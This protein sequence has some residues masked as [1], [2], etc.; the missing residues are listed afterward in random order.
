[1]EKCPDKVCKMHGNH[2]KLYSEITAAKYA[3]QMQYDYKAKFA[4]HLAAKKLKQ[5]ARREFLLVE[6]L[7]NG[8]SLPVNYRTFKDKADRKEKKQIVPTREA[9]IIID[10]SDSSRGNVVIE[11]EDVM[12]LYQM[13]EQGKGGGREAMNR[14]SSVN[15]DDEES[16]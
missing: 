8:Y 6:A 4:G 1:M 7:E 14:S 5:E 16:M 9:P 11:D 3:C 10:R 15:S 13:Q 12:L 2:G